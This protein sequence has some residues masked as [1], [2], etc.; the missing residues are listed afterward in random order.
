MA[1]ETRDKSIKFRSAWPP[2]RNI[3]YYLL[4]YKFDK[5][6]KTRLHVYRSICAYARF[7]DQKH[8]MR[9][10][11]LRSILCTIGRIICVFFS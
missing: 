5:I 8:A 4:Y 11:N 1:A 6:S 2:K 3:I 7:M 10:I 9:A